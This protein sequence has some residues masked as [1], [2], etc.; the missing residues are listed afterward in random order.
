MIAVEASVS[1]G[2]SNKRFSAIEPISVSHPS[3]QHLLVRHTLLHALLANRRQHH[4]ALALVYF[5]AVSTVGANVISGVIEAFKPVAV[6][7]FAQDMAGLV[8]NYQVV[9]KD[10]HVGARNVPA[11]PPHHDVAPER[12]EVAP[13]FESRYVGAAWRVGPDVYFPDPL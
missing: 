13:E 11:P 1:K 7:M 10:V 8:L 6:Y 2:P 12:V 4:A 5:A 9:G 3:S